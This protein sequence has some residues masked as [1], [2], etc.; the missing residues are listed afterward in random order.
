MSKWDIYAFDWL[1]ETLESFNE[2][3]G[4]SHY[5]YTQNFPPM[6]SFLNEESGELTLEFALA[7][8]EAKNLELTISGDKLKLC[9]KAEAKTDE[10]KVLKQGI[11]LRDFEARYGLP[12]GKFNSEDAK[13]SF[14]NGMLTVRLTPAAGKKP[15]KINIEE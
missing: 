4:D 12:A 15:I 8:F 6:N 11:R 1:G 9:G 2:L 5:A 3:L 10:R 7:G 14:K 13:V